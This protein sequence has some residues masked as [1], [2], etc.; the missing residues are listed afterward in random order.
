MIWSANRRAVASSLTPAVVQPAINPALSR[1]PT[2]RNRQPREY[3]ALHDE[4]DWIDGPLTTP[5]LFV[6]I[7]EHVSASTTR[8][9]FEQEPETKV[10]RRASHEVGYFFLF[11][12]A[13]S[14]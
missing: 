10:I 1:S 5:A 7:R 8:Q 9:D 14:E 4:L 13:I 6:R 2:N 3:R 11:Q 12:L